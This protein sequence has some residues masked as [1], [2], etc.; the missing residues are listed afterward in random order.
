[1]IY[2]T[3]EQ[4]AQRYQVSPDTLKEWRYKGTGPTFLRLG[5]RVRYREVDLEV[6]ERER[7]GGGDAA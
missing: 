5:K 4:V 1:M 3:P 6:W 7:E 2:L